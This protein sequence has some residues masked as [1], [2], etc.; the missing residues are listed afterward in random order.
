MKFTVL[1]VAVLASVLGLLIFQKYS[2]SDKLMKEKK[3]HRFDIITLNGDTIIFSKDSFPKKLIFNF[4]SSSC[5]ICMFEVNDIVSFS[6]KNDIDVL[7]I[8]ADSL[9]SMRNFARDIGNKGGRITFA[10]IA[11]VDA[12]KLFGELTV[13]QTILFDEGLEIKKIKK[14][15]VSTGL[16]NKSFE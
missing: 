13:P 16:L 9:E 10:K 8:T 12:E 2:A 14:G 1:I 5:D 3:I 6:T 4:Y 7:F 15:L 11:L